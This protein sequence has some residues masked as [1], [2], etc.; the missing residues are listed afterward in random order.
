MSAVETSAYD[1]QPP[2]LGTVTLP[3]TGPVGEPVRISKPPLGLGEA[4]RA[5]KEVTP[6]R[7]TSSYAAQSPGLTKPSTVPPCAGVCG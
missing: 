6:V 1:S 3:S 2:V 5:V 4:T 7:S